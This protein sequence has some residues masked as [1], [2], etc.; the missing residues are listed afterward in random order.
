MSS[1][2]VSVNVYPEESP[3]RGLLL[4]PMAVML[5][6]SSGLLNAVW[7]L[8][9]KQSGHKVVFLWSFQWIGIVAFMPWALMAISH[10]PVAPR[11]WLLLL[12]TASVHGAYVILLSLTYSAGDLSSVYPL[13]RGTSP[14]LVPLLGILLLGEHLSSLGWL[15]VG[16]VVTGIVVLGGWLSP[17]PSMIR[18]R[19]PKS[20]GLAL[21][22]GLLIAAYTTLDKVTLHYVPAVALNDGSNLANLI[23]LSWWAIRSGAIKTEWAANWK[24]IVLTGILSPGGYLL[25]LLALRIAPVAQLA[26]MREVGIVFATLLG[27]VMLKETEG[28]K[29]MIAA[30]LITAGAILLGLWG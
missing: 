7:N 18:S 16:A 5:V 13:M 25:F 2:W 1:H 9:A 24:V 10:H 14:L 8:F 22:V 21:A 29:R 27:L 15:G 17:A 30:G 12:V 20:T 28:R 4:F 26:P 23:A 6:M 11:G 3:D 19:V